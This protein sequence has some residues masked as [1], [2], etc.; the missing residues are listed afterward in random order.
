MIED[1]RNEDFKTSLEGIGTIKIRRSTKARYMRLKVDPKEG[2]IVVVPRLVSESAAYNFVLRKKSWI[3]K[4]L[5]KQ[6]FIKKQNTVFTENSEFTTRTHRLHLLKH[7]KKTIKSI[8][9]GNKILVWYPDFAEVEHQTIQKTIRRTIE[10]TWRLEAKKYLPVRVDELANKF[11]FHYRKL[12]IKKAKTRWGS[13]SAENN[14]N[15]NIQLM[16]LSDQLI[17]YVILHELMHTKEKNH[18]PAFWNG[19]EKILPGARKLDKELNKYNLT[20]W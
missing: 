17:D 3:V 10:E 19:L 6:A 9:S 13:C 7:P 14:I 4:S 1:L 12:N 15:L 5:K 20:F 2:V 8:V 11:G 18:Q 16:R